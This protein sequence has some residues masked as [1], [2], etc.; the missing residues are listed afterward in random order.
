MP[1]AIIT[2][3]ISAISILAGSTLGAL[4]SWI[5]S[6]KMHNQKMQEEY[7]I[8]Q[9]NR[10]YEDSYRAKEVCNN[11][12]VIRLDIANAL[13]Q[14]IRSLQ[15]TDEKKNYLYLLPINKYYSQ[16]VASLS[17]KYNLKELSYLYQ[18]YGII[19]K[20][21]RDIYEWTI[22]DTEAYDKVKTGFETILYK[23]YG[24]DFKK[25]L[26]I[27]PDNISYIELYK[28]DSTEKQYKDLLEKLDYLCLLENLLKEKTE[29]HIKK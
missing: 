14:S 6:K 7:K 5:I 25:V 18:L 29:E 8:M 2:T 11:A 10:K 3:I 17:D 24:D 20:V 15:N 21:N 4:F 22:G 9:E 23:M 28:N 26:T 12:N 27:D 13:F 16:A 19:E 1:I